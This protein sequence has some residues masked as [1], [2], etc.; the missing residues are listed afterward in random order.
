MICFVCE[1]SPDSP[2]KEKK[3]SKR[4]NDDMRKKIQEDMVA[5]E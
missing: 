4:R 5:W 3:N 1:L 2:N